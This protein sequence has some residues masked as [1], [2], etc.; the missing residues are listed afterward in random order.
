MT[1]DHSPT[2]HEYHSEIESLAEQ[3]KAEDPVDRDDVEDA[4]DWLHQT[5]DGHEFVIYTAKAWA[6]CWHSQ[7]EDAVFEDGEAL[8]DLDNMGSI[9]CRAAYYAMRADVH[10]R[11]KP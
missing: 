10:E 4:E 7:H 3:Y 2:Y 5:I 9:M 1:Q 8:G 11:A 6:V